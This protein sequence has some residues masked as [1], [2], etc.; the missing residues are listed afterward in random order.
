MK[1]TIWKCVAVVLAA[2]G[3]ATAI[4]GNAVADKAAIEKAIASYVAAFNA[5]DSAELASHWSPEAVYTNPRTGDQVVGLE[6]IKQ[7]FDALLADA[8]DVKLEV[9]VESIDFVSPNVAV[10]NGLATVSGP[11]SVAEV[12]RYQAVHVKQGGKWLLDRVS[13]EEVTSP[14]SHYEQL[15]PLEWLI[16][17]WVDEDDEARVETT[18]QWS[19]NQNFITRSFTIDLANEPPLSGVQFI[20]WDA[21]LGKIHSWAFDS[22]GG[23]VEGTWSNKDGSWIVESSAVL[24]DGRKASSINIMKIL[25]DKTLSWQV[26]GRDVDGEILPNLPEVKITRIASEQ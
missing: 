23:V 26:T 15:K 4:A 20:G 25:D 6:A 9:E 3:P 24:P 21:A 8:K 5:H 22:D 19:K 18:C 17:S 12:T 7:E 14:P 10:E 1:R 16:G 11:E 2:C 13:E